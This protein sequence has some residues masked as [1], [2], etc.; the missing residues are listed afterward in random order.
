MG[1]RPST[2]SASSVETFLSAFG[3]T[4]ATLPDASEVEGIFK[5]K[6]ETYFTET[7]AIARR[8][9]R[10]FVPSSGVGTLARDQAIT[11]SGDD[12]NLPDSSVS[13][14]VVDLADDHDGW[15]EVTLSRRSN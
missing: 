10:L 8:A 11:L 15:T 7:E 5:T 12:P 1:A 4:T 9:Y 13:F 2:G 14:N 6:R 3:A